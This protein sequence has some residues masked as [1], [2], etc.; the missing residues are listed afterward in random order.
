MER[1]LDSYKFNLLHCKQTFI[2]QLKR[3]QL[4][5]R[6]L[7]EGAI[8]EKSGMNFSEY[9]AI[10]SGNTDLLERA[11]LEKRIVAL[12]GERKNFFREQR[13]QEAKIRSLMQANERYRQHISDAEGD[14][15]KFTKAAGTEP[16]NT[17]TLDGFTVPDGFAAGT[18]D[19]DKAVGERL[20][21][22]DNTARTQGV[23]LAVGNIHGF[24]CMVKTTEHIRHDENGNE[25]VEYSNQF[26][27]EGNHLYYSHNDGYLNHASPRIS[28]Q[29]FLLALQ[30]IPKSI[31]DW[32]HH[33]ADNEA[34]I[35]QLRQIADRQ[36]PR[37]SSLR[38]LKADLAKLDR[39]INSELHKDE[40]VDEQRKAA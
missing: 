39:K 26:Y 2:Q 24:R 38:N 16:V 19:Y 33:V 32:K 28:G 9:M 23:H 35:S 20:L 30:R 8:D 7:D 15:R 34:T 10:L 21:Q 40:K 22:I 12:E 1:S 14:W 13:E 27:V 37:E 6:T 31:K 5:K 36:W 17:V 18:D 25:F 29:T 4:A 11:K 3:G